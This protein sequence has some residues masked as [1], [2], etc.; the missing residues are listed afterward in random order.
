MVQIVGSLSS[1]TVES[2]TLALESVDDVEGGNSL[3]LGVLGVSNGVS[4]DV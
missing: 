4:D 3:S 2:S 1:E